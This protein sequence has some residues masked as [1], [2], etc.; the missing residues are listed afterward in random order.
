MDVCLNAWFLWRPEE[1]VGFPGSRVVDSCEG[2]WVL[3]MEPRS[4]PRVAN[5]LNH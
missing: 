4:S 5:A 2:P 3:G 1:D